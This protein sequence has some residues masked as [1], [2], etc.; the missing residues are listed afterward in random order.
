MEKAR[1]VAE[2]EKLAGWVGENRG[3]QVIEEAGNWAK[4]LLA[5]ADLL[6]S[7]SGSCSGQGGAGQ[8]SPETIELILKLMRIRQQE[9][10]LRE[11][12][13]FL[14]EQ[15]AVLPIY[16]ESA[17]KLGRIQDGLAKQVEELP[18]R[19]MCSKIA[20]LLD[21]V[22]EAM[23]DASRLLYKPQTD[24][25]TVA[26]ETEVIELLSSSCRGAGA[27]SGLMAALMQMLGMNAGSTGGGSMAGGTTE[28][29]ATSATGSATGAPTET[30][31]V[32]KAGGRGD[33]NLPAEFRHALEAYFD[34]VERMK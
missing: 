2:L 13:R 30:R 31:H 5:W 32:E 23:G 17:T 28:H 34:A 22:T 18:G 7:Q 9:E 27:G 4:Q 29:E 3:A 6:G 25:E 19:Y 8:L 16:E 14:E 15:R 33:G 1:V 24:G 12:T 26:A 20:H 11:S 21:Q 10:G